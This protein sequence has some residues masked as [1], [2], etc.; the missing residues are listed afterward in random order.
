MSGKQKDDLGRTTIPRKIVFFDCES[1]VDTETE[2]NITH[3]RFRLAAV[4]TYIHV[5]HGRYKETDARVVFGQDQLQRYVIGSAWVN[6]RVWVMAHNLTY[7][8]TVGGFWRLFRCGDLVLDL[9]E[10]ENVIRTGDNP[11]TPRNMSGYYPLILEDPPIVIP[12]K[13]SD[14]R[15]LVFVDSLNYFRASLKEIGKWAGIEK[16][17]MPEW[18]ADDNV[19][20]E[21]CLHDVRVLASAVT[22]L[23]GWWYG[24]NLGRWRTTTPSLAMTCFRSR[25]LQRKLIQ[26]YEP[27]VRVLERSAYYGGRT[28]PFFIGRVQ[29]RIYKLDVNSMYPYV[30]HSYS[31]PCRYVTGVETEGLDAVPPVGDYEG[32]IARVEVEIDTPIVPLRTKRGVIYPVGRFVTTLAGPELGLV[33][34]RGKILRWGAWAVYERDSIFR[35]YVEYFHALKESASEQSDAAGRQLAKLLLNSLYGKFGQ[36]G[37]K[38]KLVPNAIALPHYGTYEEV[39]AGSDTITKLLSW[40]PYVLQQVDDDDCR[41][42]W[43]AIAAYVTSYARVYL[44]R[45][46]E[47]AGWEHVYYCATDSVIVDDV[48]LEK[49]IEAGLTSSSRLGHL[50]LEAEAED[51]ECRGIHWYRL[52]DDWT[53][54]CVK[55]AAT[56]VGDG[57]WI[58]DKWISLAGLLRAGL[59]DDYIT[60]RIIKQKAGGYF[61]GRIMEDGRVLPYDAS[62]LVGDLLPVSFTLGE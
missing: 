4:G 40:P 25:F 59:P 42:A 10:S 7:D 36:R 17:A 48:G 33:A 46:I 62:E 47:T 43:P 8:L 55:P 41:V 31:Y 56:Q 61:G 51:Y 6:P 50:K 60:S 29:D 18:A 2:T 19:W 35:R 30:M 5:G 11:H 9:I 27:W 39:V 49:L 32:I 21:Y 57:V 28:Q 44:L 34:Q 53:I 22:K 13:T 24:Q 58:E 45:I 54:G 26:P 52:D 37:G 23:I 14:G 3:H 12:A 20:A 16:M 1:H 38:W 15:R